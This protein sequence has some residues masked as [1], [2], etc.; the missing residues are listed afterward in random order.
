M[1]ITSQSNERLLLPLLSVSYDIRADFHTLFM[2]ILKGVEC[3]DDHIQLEKLNLL[4][5]SY[6][7]SRKGSICPV[8]CLE[9]W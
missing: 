3:V 4:S 9:D 6:Q 1:F 8:A 2:R 5:D 7:V